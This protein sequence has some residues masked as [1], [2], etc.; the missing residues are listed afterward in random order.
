[1]TR[2]VI[3]IVLALLAGC[4]YISLHLSAC[5]N[6]F[7][8][9]KTNNFSFRDL[10]S[11][12][13]AVVGSAGLYFIIERIKKADQQIKNQER[14]LEEQQNTNF[15]NSLHQGLEMLHSDAF[16]KQIGGID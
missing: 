7:S 5:Q 16:N 6:I 15:L 14:Q 1:M 11:V 10:L 13:T 12:M 2:F 9:L 4:G 8:L 3:T